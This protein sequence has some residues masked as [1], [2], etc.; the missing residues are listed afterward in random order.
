MITPISMVNFKNLNINFK[1]N[2]QDTGRTTAPIKEINAD[3][4]TLSQAGKE[5]S[6]K[7]I[8]AKDFPEEISVS[9]LP[10]VVSTS[11]AVIN[12]VGDLYKKGETTRKD[13]SRTQI[14]DMEHNGR[15]LMYEYSDF[16]QPTRK[17]IFKD[18]KLY[19]VRIPLENNDNETR[20]IIIQTY[21]DG[22]TL[23]MFEITSGDKS[24]KGHIETKINFDEDGHIASFM[25]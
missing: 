11:I 15:E 18:G 2:K 19:E 13:G 20:Q 25:G 9:N 10:E 4:F 16:T 23:K 24:G 8:S 12:E 21:E 5:E 3:T 6:F 17:S 22:K 1:G 14:V 7:A